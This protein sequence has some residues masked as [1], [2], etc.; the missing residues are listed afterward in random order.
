MHVRH[1]LKHDN[2]SRK[3]NESEMVSAIFNWIKKSQKIHTD[4]NK[5]WA[6]MNSISDKNA[7]QKI[8]EREREKEAQQ[9]IWEDLK[10]KS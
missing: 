9:T 8:S 5:V 1:I 6:K 10:S 4:L 2:T 3:L 7:L